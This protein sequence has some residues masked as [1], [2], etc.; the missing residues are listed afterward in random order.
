MH[1]FGLFFLKPH[2][3]VKG[4]AKPLGHRALVGVNCSCTRRRRSDLLLL[5]GHGTAPIAQHRVI[6]LALVP[7]LLV[8]SAQMFVVKLTT[9]KV[10]S[11]PP[12]PSSERADHTVHVFQTI[13]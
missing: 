5:G 13:R 2:E 9:V 1:D 4:K 3:L 10:L 8:G 11:L 12:L 6:T 7:F